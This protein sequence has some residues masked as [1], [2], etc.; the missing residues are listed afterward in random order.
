MKCHPGITGSLHLLLAASF[1]FFLA[2]QQG[3]SQAA[4]TKPTQASVV[5]ALARS[6]KAEGKV[7]WYMSNG[8]RIAHRVAQAFEAKHGINVS[9]VVLE[10]PKMLQRY[11]AEAQ[12]GRIVA[13]LLTGTVNTA[14]VENLIKNGWA[15]PIS[16]S[17]IPVLQ[18]DYPAKFN[19]G[20]TRLVSAAPWQLGYNTQAVKKSDLPK[21]WKDLLDPKWKGKIIM[22]DPASSVS[23]LSFWYVLMQKYGE[24]FLKGIRAQNVRLSGSGVP[25]AQSLAA[26][27]GALLL[28]TVA[29]VVQPLKAVGAPIDLFSPTG[30]TTGIF[31]QVVM[32]R[33]DKAQH[34]NAARLFAN[35]LL[36]KEGNMVFNSDPGQIGPH[37]VK[38]L[39]DELRAPS[40]EMLKYKDQI[41]QLL[42]G[43]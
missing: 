11:A 17:A 42:I 2:P 41:V 32:T 10:T 12:G 15:E 1:S 24:D 19:E 39:P 4:S 43:K 34:P 28:P 36:S 27:E 26:G 31:S 6:A 13:D 35:F 29:G 3:W 9:L 25:A 7:T 21:D 5:E 38:D 40:P 37:N 33:A 18:T 22:P 30:P 23:Y 14:D 20:P 16:K 8:D